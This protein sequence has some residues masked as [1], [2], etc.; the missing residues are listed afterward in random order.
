MNLNMNKQIRN[1]FLV[2]LILI[3]PLFAQQKEANKSM[4]GLRFDAGVTASYMTF[5]TYENISYNISFPEDTI[6]FDFGIQFLENYLFDPYFYYCP[7]VQVDIG[8]IYYV[9]LGC[10]CSV[11]TLEDNIFLPFGKAGF[12]VGNWDIGKGKGNINIGLEVSP[13][14]FFDPYCKYPGSGILESWK[15]TI[16]NLFKL[17]IGFDYYLPL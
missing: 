15:A 12:L 17:T 13:T 3:A 1:I 10:L 6:G 9:G 14:R 5:F 7:F 4:T 16:V 11:S 2:S 8:K